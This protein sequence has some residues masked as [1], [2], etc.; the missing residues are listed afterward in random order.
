MRCVSASSSDVAVTTAGMAARLASVRF[1]MTALKL[2]IK[3]LYNLAKGRYGHRPIHDHL[4]DEQ[5][6]CGH[7]RSLRLMRELGIAGVQ[8][9]GF[10]PLGTDSNHKF[11]YSANL[12]KAL[13]KPERPDKSGWPIPHTYVLRVAG[14]I[15]Q[16]SWICLVVVS[17]VGVL[18]TATTRR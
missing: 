17:L 12:L 15:W 3:E 9:K 11:G 8:K 13:S 7:D 10:K 18:A 5:L 16:L 2:R 6:D 4:K 14:A 1:R